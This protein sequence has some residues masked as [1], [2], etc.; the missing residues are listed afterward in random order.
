MAAG[1]AFA[2]LWQHGK[3]GHRDKE[4]Q[5]DLNTII[6]GT[7]NDEVT[8]HR[9]KPTRSTSALGFVKTQ[10]AA[11]NFQ[12]PPPVFPEGKFFSFWNQVDMMDAATQFLEV[13]LK[14]LNEL[15]RETLEGEELSRRK[16][17]RRSWAFGLV[18][19]SKE[20]STDSLPGSPAIE[21]AFRLPPPK[22]QS[23]N[24][25]TNM[26]FTVLNTILVLALYHDLDLEKGST[27]RLLEMMKQSAGDRLNSTWHQTVLHILTLNNQGQKR[28]ISTIVGHCAACMSSHISALNNNIIASGWIYL[29]LQ[30]RALDGQCAA[31]MRGLLKCVEL[32]EKDPSTVV[33]PAHELQVLSLLFMIRTLFSL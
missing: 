21:R 8:G 17:S 33:T 18:Y 5:N 11:V 19:H 31:V 14:R 24:I 3:A 4:L 30:E 16:I 26:K 23:F 28:N 2:F 29:W 15:D 13:L 32:I 27:M 20:Q 9:K 25:K 6:K 22:E 1:K 10:K 12:P 7:Y